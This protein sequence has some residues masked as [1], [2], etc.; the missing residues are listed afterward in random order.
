MLNLS[1]NLSCFH[2]QLLIRHS[3]LLNKSLCFLTSSIHPLLALRFSTL[4]SFAISNAFS[5]KMFPDTGILLS[6]T[7]LKHFISRPST[8]SKFDAH[9]LFRLQ[10]VWQLLKIASFVDRIV[11]NIDFGTECTLENPGLF[12][13]VISKSVINVTF[14]DCAHDFQQAFSFLN[15]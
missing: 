13:P 3:F 4:N 9:I 1:T 2:Q 5:F 10:S 12:V 15:S 14:S 7:F 8:S 6:Q 11:F